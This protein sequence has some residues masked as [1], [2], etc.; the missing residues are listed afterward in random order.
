VAA[1]S[2]LFRH[3]IQVKESAAVT[4][5]RQIMLQSL[6]EIAKTYAEALTKKRIQS[7]AKSSKA[8]EEALQFYNAVIAD[9][10]H[11]KL[12]AT[13]PQ[14]AANKLA[15]KVSS[16][17]LALVEGLVGAVGG[18]PKPEGPAE[19]VIAVAIGVAL[20]ARRPEEAGIVIDSSAD[21]SLKL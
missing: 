12:L 15:L 14:E 11:I 17:A 9:G 13:K 19:V 10:R 2:L 20:A 18:S 5:R 3:P 4:K 16:E 21:V 1:R 8:G 6:P 7:L